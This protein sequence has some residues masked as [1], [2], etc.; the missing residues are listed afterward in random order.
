MIWQTATNVVSLGKDVVMSED[1]P[2][3]NDAKYTYLGIDNQVNEAAIADNYQSRIATIR[4]GLSYNALAYFMKRTGLSLAELAP[5]FQV[6]TRTLQRYSAHD[7]LPPF[8][9]ERLILL[10]DLFLQAEGS[11]GKDGAQIAE[12][13]RTPNDALGRVAPLSLL[14]TY[15]GF[16][17]VSNVL[18]RLEWGVFS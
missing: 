11:L 5:V 10:N 14:D 9:S 4:S 3:Y 6:S 2:I 15:R 1:G 17:E 16:E 18:G 12:W 8:I 13:L 7:S